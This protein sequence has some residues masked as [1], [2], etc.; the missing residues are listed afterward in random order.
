MTP[1]Q[2][3][4]A[5]I[6]YLWTLQKL[7]HLSSSQAALAITVASFNEQVVQITDI[8]GSENQF[9]LEKQGFE[10][11]KHICTEK[12]FV[13]ED[14]VEDVVYKETSALLNKCTLYHFTHVVHA[15]A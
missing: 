5:T 6:N 14:K 8:R 3:I 10:V 13:D 1:T 2:I 15:V 11:C 7:V 4:N 12:D 9:K